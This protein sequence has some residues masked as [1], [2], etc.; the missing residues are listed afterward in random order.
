M[1]RKKNQKA[2]MYVI[3]VSTKQKVQKYRYNRNRKSEILE[4]LFF[5]ILGAVTQQHILNKG[6]RLIN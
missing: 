2:N 6:Q 3:L 4:I 5:T 1:F